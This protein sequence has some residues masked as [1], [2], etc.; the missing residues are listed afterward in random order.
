MAQE[1]KNY[2]AVSLCSDIHLGYVP[3]IAQMT[4]TG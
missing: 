3:T 2:L 4:L 1:G